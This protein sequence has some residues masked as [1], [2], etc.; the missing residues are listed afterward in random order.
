MTASSS[1]FGR[2]LRAWRKREGLT[3]RDLADRVP[4]SYSHLSRMESGDRNPPARRGVIQLAQALSGN[5][6]ELLAMAGYAAEGTGFQGPPQMS[7]DATSFG[8]ARY[9]PTADE[10]RVINEA[11]AEQVFF[12]A[13]TEPGFWNDTPDDRRAA[14]RYLEG[15]IDEARRYRRRQERR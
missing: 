15:L 6:D 4:F 13:L 5:V 10:L 2:L 8:D 14:F 1:A 9:E 12:G 3:L 11:N 7:V